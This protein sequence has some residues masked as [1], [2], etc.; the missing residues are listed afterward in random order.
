MPRL[1]WSSVGRFVAGCAL[2]LATLAGVTPVSAQTPK[3]V[4]LLF[5]E[6]RSLPGLAVLDQ[7]FRA[8]LTAASD[9]ASSS[10][11]SR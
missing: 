1:Q 9:M 10:M 4:L 3:R 8:A 2:A 11:P 6:D 5:D 7:G